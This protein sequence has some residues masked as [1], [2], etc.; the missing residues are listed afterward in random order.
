MYVAERVE[1]VRFYKCPLIRK[2]DIKWNA[3]TL[4]IDCRQII[5]M[6]TF[7]QKPT[8]YELNQ[9]KNSSYIPT[10]SK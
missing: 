7:R 3:F 8:Y 10:V 6:S 9:T 2:V 1:I 5:R 4:V